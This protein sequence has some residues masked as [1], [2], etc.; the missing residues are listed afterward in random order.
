MVFGVVFILVGLFAVAAS[1][2]NWNFFFEH[3]K[4]R[5]FVFLFGGRLGARIFYALLGAALIVL[6]VLGLTGVIDMSHQG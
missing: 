3:R 2:L 5:V 6:G 1:L 4:A